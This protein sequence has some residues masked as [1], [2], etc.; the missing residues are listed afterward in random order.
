VSRFD[1][2]GLFLTVSGSPTTPVLFFVN[3]GTAVGSFASVTLGTSLSEAL[4]T[5]AAGG[6]VNAGG[7]NDTLN[8]GNGVDYLVG[9]A[10]NDTLNGGAGNDTLLGGAGDD[11]LNGG[12]GI[13]RIDGG[14]GSDVYAFNAGE[15]DSAETIT[16]TGTAG[17]DTLNI[18]SNAPL[19]D[20]QFAGKVGF[21]ALTTR[22]NVGGSQDSVAEVT[23]GAVAQASGIV[24]VNSNDDDLN[25]SA[26]TVG[27]TVNG[28]GSISTGSGAD[29]VNLVNFNTNPTI[30]PVVPTA[31]DFQFSPGTVSLGAGDDTLNAGFALVNPSG[32][33]DGGAGNDTLVYGRSGTGQGGLDFT[34]PANG[35]NGFNANIVN[36]E[37][38]RIITEDGAVAVEG[39]NNDRPGAAN[40]Y[41]FNV[42]D[43]N[44]GTVLT[45][46]GSTLRAGVV[47]AL[48]SDNEIGGTGT[49]ADTLID[50]VLTVNASALTAGRAVNVIGGA[51]N[52]IL[53]GGAGNDTLNGGAGND[54]LAGG[55]GNDTLIGG[56]GNDT[57][58]FNNGELTA[59]DVVTGGLGNDTLR[60]T[61]STPLVDAVFAG[62]T[63][64]QTLTTDVQAG[65]P[66]DSI[67]EVTLGAAAQAAGIRNVNN[68]NDDLNA[69]AYTADLV[70]R[71][72]TGG[73]IT[74]SGND[75]VA[76]STATPTATPGPINTGAGD[77]TV[78]LFYNGP[79]TANQAT[80]LVYNG[81]TGND[82][83]ILGF[84]LSFWTIG[85][86]Q[87][88]PGGLRG[89]ANTAVNFNFNTGLTNVETIRLVSAEAAV[90]VDGAAND[91]AGNTVAF[92]LSVVD[93]N[94]VSGGTLTVDGSGLTAGVATALGADGEI[95]GTGANADTLTANTLTFTAAGLTGNRAVNVSGG[96]GNDTL[97][98]GV[99]N[100]TLNGGAGVDTLVGGAGL[101]TLSGGDGN[102]TLDGGTGND[103][104]N[105]DAGND[106][107][108]GGD[109]NDTI[110][111]GA[112][113]DR[114]IVTVTQ[115]GSDN[116]QVDGGDGTDTLSILATTPTAE[117]AD[118]GFNGRYR[119]T[120]VVELTGAAG[121]TVFTYSAG[122]FA[123]TA[124][125]R[126]I[127]LGA[128]ASGSVSIANYTSSGTTVNG[129]TGN[130][131]L[132]G[133]GF[134]DTFT[135]G[136]GTDTINT[137]AGNDVVT[138]N[139]AGTTTVDLGMGNDRVNTGTFLDAAD[140]LVG[141]SG[142]DTIAIGAA[143]TGYSGQ[144]VTFN[145]NILGFETVV[146]AAGLAP[147]D[148]TAPTA[149]VVGTV[150]NY[151][152][153][154]Q[155]TSFVAGTADSTLTIDASALRA[156][157]IIGLGGNGVIG[158]GDDMTASENLFLNAG[159]LAANHLLN[160]TG[161][162]GADILNGGAA[163]DI[164]SGG[165]GGDSLSGGAGNDTLT[166]GN[167]ADVIIGGT[168][169]DTI[170]L[171]ES[172]AAR[173][174][175]IVNDLDSARVNNDTITGF[176]VDTDGIAGLNAT[177]DVI[178]FGSA[179]LTSSAVSNGV[180]SATS[181][182]G[183]NL[184]QIENTTGSFL[185]AIQLI[186][187]EFQAETGQQGGT[188][189]FTFRG[190]TYIGEI[191]G[192]AGFESFTD[193]VRLQGTTGVT[194]LFDVD[195]GGAGTAVGLIA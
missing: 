131:T 20:S 150:N 141:G 14:E 46:D 10:G 15:F 128:N 177:A 158:G 23:L 176:G 145:A 120:E 26:Y 49:A 65:T 151:N 94:I 180:V 168:G 136:G 13:D 72:G 135:N 3:D 107:L 88:A 32:L 19:T 73:V 146:L 129:G 41:T 143:A 190:D 155:D 192:T 175:V 148:N 9:G 71:T 193:I 57:Y 40:S 133:S 105:G 127:N 87:T 153:T 194:S 44:V 101:D 171:G 130:D 124:G 50:E 85:I 179:I 36:F 11:L 98:G 90:A 119:N 121:G 173:D 186:E 157:V 174:T 115:F 161:G 33:I 27:L 51:A 37:A 30:A 7:G 163:N 89:S 116:D 144:A 170:N 109:G 140:V 56:A 166:G 159:G 58:V 182:L 160:V 31:A 191:T 113:N 38:I 134:D 83:L 183:I 2:E 139:A 165:D 102:D 103:T 110:N 126:L 16:D 68:G 112:G 142:T 48:G 162:A 167:G 125:V 75:N 152:L 43:A 123:E 8:G 18:A 195:G 184:A 63:G 122:T 93:A 77:D 62:V 80:N 67:F 12:A 147:I 189:A 169:A 55:L 156:N 60:V 111:G 185:A 22:V 118:V 64:V 1:D 97:T 5:A 39:S 106:T 92:N 21:E 132:T 59:A 47:V 149:D 95:G 76:I 117:I 35:I 104:L 78:N 74:G 61:Q 178:D 17:V 25:A 137:G 114:I 79:L 138:F 154:V 108:T 70:V 69:V 91:I 81:S 86:A 29:T 34:G 82:T 6:Y 52:D 100:D 96:A 66:G 188:V 53:T 164:L 24:T 54:T 42:V 28:I 187:Q 4:N 84:N 181:T 172:V 45:I 99:G